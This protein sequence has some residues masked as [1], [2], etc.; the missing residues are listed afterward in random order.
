MHPIQTNTTE[1]YRPAGVSIFGDEMHSS[2]PYADLDTNGQRVKT[3]ET[4]RL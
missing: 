2:L 4:F 3:W 1:Y